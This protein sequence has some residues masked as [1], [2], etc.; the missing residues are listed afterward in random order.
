MTTSATTRPDGDD[1][2]EHQQQA[3]AQRHRYSGGGPQ[4]V[5]DAPDGVDQAGARG[6][7]IFLRR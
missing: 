7:S 1:A 4:G 6:E 2:D 5:A 3:Q